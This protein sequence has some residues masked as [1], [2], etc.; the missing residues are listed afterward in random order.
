MLPAIYYYHRLLCHTL[1]LHIAI[2]HL[3]SFFYFDVSA[4]F[5][6]LLVFRLKFSTAL[7]CFTN[8]PAWR[9]GKR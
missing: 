3:R 8:N 9:A 2:Q 5:T 1:V 4:I 6:P 7:L